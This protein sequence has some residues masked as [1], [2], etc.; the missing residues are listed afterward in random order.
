MQA[1]KSSGKRPR[2]IRLDFFRGLCLF[3]IFV[4]HIFENAW[5]A[6][7]PA[8]FGFSDATEIFVFCSGMASAIAFGGI[9]LARGLAMGTARIAFRIWQVYW[10]H[11]AVFMV[12]VVLVVAVDQWLVTKGHFIKVLMMDALFDG[13]A[14]DAVVGLLTLRFVPPFFDILPMYLAILGMVPVVMALHRL[15]GQQAAAAFVLCVWL[16]SSFKLLELSREPWGPEVWYFNPF[17]W[18]LVFFTGFAFM[19]GWLP[20]PIVDK[21]L[22]WAAV[23][24]VAIS[25]P[26][27]WQPALEAV[28]VLREVREAIGVLIDKTH[29]GPLRFAHFLALA[30]LSYVVVGEGGRRLRGPIVGLI[31]RVGQQSLAVFVS[32]LVLSFMATMFLDAVGRTYFTVPFANIAGMASLVAIAYTVSWF[33]SAPWAKPVER[34]V[35]VAGQNVSS[36]ANSPERTVTNWSQKPTPA[37]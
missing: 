29:V 5:G 12:S 35:R 31:C 13:R 1:S 19:R 10:A 32:G 15:R 9:F 22:I 34:T 20:A 16:A 24:V 36:V 3:I 7:I 6:W 11:I 27:E 14:Q 23:A 4:A 28:P 21:R 2:D 37:E 8:R 33:K 30:Y 17:S 25:L 26:L 18:Q